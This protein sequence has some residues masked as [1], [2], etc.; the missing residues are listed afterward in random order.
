MQVEQVDRE[1]GGEI[2]RLLGVKVLV[3]SQA[4]DLGSILATHREAAR[5]EGI[6]LG[7]EAAAGV[8]DAQKQVFM[9]EEYA[10]GQPMSSFMER[11]ACGCCSDAIRAI[12]PAVIGAGQ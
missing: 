6:R 5:I 1:R 9:S 4:F 2:I 8:C 11:F 10:V 3:G 7:L 12:D